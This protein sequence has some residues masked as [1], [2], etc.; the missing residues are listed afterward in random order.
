MTR[1]IKEHKFISI[2]ILAAIIACAVTFAVCLGNDEENM[3]AKEKSIEKTVKERALQCY[4]IEDAYPESLEYLEKNYGLAVNKKDYK[5]IYTPF[6]ENMPPQ[7][8]VIYR[9]GQ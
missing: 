7:I 6:A 2:C 9:G 3:Q 8:K 4:V 5:I 1:I